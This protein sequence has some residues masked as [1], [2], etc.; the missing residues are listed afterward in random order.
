[1]NSKDTHLGV[2]H[3]RADQIG[4]QQVRGKLDAGKIGMN[5]FG[6]RFNQKGFARPGTPSNKTCPSASS[7]VKTRSTNFSCP[8]IT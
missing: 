3:L 8:T 1:M 6:S 5:S 7:A 2:V 4:G